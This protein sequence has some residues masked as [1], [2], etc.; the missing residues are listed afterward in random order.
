[1]SNW[2][3]ACEELPESGNVLVM[4]LEPFFGQLHPEVTVAYYDN[5][6]DY[7]KP[8]DA[9]GW[10]Q[11]PSGRPIFHVTHWMKIP[12]LPSKSEYDFVKQG[13]MNEDKYNTVHLNKK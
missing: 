11:D 1:M 13:Q 8:E 12:E 4:Y 3:K 9:K 5:P 7:E 6:N 2:K 10:T